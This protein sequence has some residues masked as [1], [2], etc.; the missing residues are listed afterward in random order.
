MLLR[1]FLTIETEALNLI[2]PTPFDF[3]IRLKSTPL[4]TLAAKNRDNF[5]PKSSVSRFF[6]RWLGSRTLFSKKAC[7]QVEEGMEP[8]VG[9]EKRKREKVVPLLPLAEN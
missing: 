6:L 5:L 1:T 3:P 9:D 2:F 8:H 7:S 4:R